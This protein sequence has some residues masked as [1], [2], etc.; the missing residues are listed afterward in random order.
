[1][2]FLCYILGHVMFTCIL[3]NVVGFEGELRTGIKLDILGGI[4]LLIK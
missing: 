3:F 2:Y 1:M 4:E